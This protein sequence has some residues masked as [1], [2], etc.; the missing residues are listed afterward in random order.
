MVV[1]LVSTS[2][3]LTHLSH[4]RLALCVNRDAFLSA[5]TVEWLKRCL[6]FNRFYDRD[7][8]L[9]L[10]KIFLNFF[11]S[12]SYSVSLDSHSNI[13]SPRVVI[14]FKYH[15]IIFASTKELSL[16]RLKKYQR[17]TDILAL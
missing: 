11:P 15:S 5:A 16:E 10:F 8:L 2:R 14:S 1:Y 13:R 9:T 3:I 12:S 17:T 6:I 7:L 4:T